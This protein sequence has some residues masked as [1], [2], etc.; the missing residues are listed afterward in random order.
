M[1]IAYV[2][3][4]N[5]QLGKISKEQR[6]GDCEVW[7]NHLHNPDFARYAEVFRVLGIRVIAADALSDALDRAAGHDGPAL[8][9]VI[10]DPDLI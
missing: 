8:V 3:L 7:R 4:K 1:N 9:E 2:L 10:T 5:G 6:A